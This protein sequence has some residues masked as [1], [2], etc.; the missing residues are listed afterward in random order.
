[1]N[2]HGAGPRSG[3]PAHESEGWTSFE[4][5]FP[6]ELI[7]NATT[8]FR[9]YQFR[10]YGSHILICALVA[11]LGPAILLGFGVPST[12]MVLPAAAALL[13][14]AWITYKYFF[15]PRMLAAKLQYTLA[16][17]GTVKVSPMAISIPIRD[18]KE[19]VFQW[20]AIGAV[21][22]AKGAFLL[23][24]SPV[25]TY[26]VPRLGMPDAIAEAFRRKTQS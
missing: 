20:S 19:M 25:S 16:P 26:P 14:P 7:D 11:L 15:G 5:K 3:D 8:A 22:E 21:L 1:M 12:S 4:A 23:V 10:R 17:A 24:L 18:G 13:G 2:D 9:D 6:A